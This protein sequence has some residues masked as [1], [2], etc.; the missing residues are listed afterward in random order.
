MSG[1][2]SR[3][4]SRSGTHIHLDE[5]AFRAMGAGK[6]LF[7]GIAKPVIEELAARFHVRL[8]QTAEIDEVAILNSIPTAEGAI[9]R[10]MQE[11]PVTIHGSRT[12]VVGY[13]RCGITLAR[14]LQGIGRVVRV[15]AREGGQLA[16]A[17]EAGLQVDRLE[18]LGAA[19]EDARIVFNT[20]PGGAAITRETLKRMRKDAVVIDIVSA[21]GG[22]DF[23]AARE[24]GVKAMLELGLPGQRRPRSRPVRSWRVRCLRLSGPSAAYNKSSPCT[25][26]RTHR[27]ER[28]ASVEVKREDDRMGSAAPTAA[29][30]GAPA[31]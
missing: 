10:A 4:N 27:V 8:I 25:P 9:F 11:L 24:L 23:A 29:T 30:R 20:V 6:T 19:V 5:E 28:G 3:A 21:P 13:G 26:I 7:I 2:W 18:A 17:H 12:V 15:V 16:R 14:M 22:T 31:G 1:A